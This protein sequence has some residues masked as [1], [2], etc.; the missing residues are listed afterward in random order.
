MKKVS[1]LKIQQQQHRTLSWSLIS[2]FNDVK[3]KN[4][5]FCTYSVE[6][7]SLHCRTFAVQSL[8]RR[9][10][11][12]SRDTD[13]VYSLSHSCF[14]VKNRALLS[15]C[16]GSARKNTLQIIPPPEIQLCRGFGARPDSN[17]SPGSYFFS[18]LFISYW[19]SLKH[20][21]FLSPKNESLGEV[22]VSLWGLSVQQLFW[23]GALLM[24]TAT[25]NL[26][27]VK[28]SINVI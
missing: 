18:L 21:L 1:E 19:C 16:S 10:A 26:C 17:V 2:F 22:H 15:L 3:K 11:P 12:L 27:T 8:A 28:S 23:H 20:L 24:I 7:F 6:L 9:E 13:R 4:I 25:V 5:F 14:L